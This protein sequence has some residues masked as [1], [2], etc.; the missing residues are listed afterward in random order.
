VVARY[1]DELAEQGWTVTPGRP[2][3]H[4][5]FLDTP[6][7]AGFASLC[8]GRDGMELIVGAVPATDGTSE[9]RVRLDRLESQPCPVGWTFVPDRPHNPGAGLYALLPP[10]PLPDAAR[11][12]Q[13]GAAWEQTL[14]TSLSAAELEAH[15]ARHLMA[16]GWSRQVG[17]AEGPVAWSTLSGPEG[18]DVQ[19]LLVAV[20]WPASEHRLVLLELDSATNPLPGATGSS[21]PVGPAGP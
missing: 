20:Q 6:T 13:Y 21:V 16:D 12:D 3:R 18:R 5:G 9:L 11:A 10:L 19:G 4:D 1:R 7:T 14:Q 15:Y 2:P 17:T 8:A